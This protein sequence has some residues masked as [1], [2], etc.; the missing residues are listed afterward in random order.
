VDALEAKTVA[1]APRIRPFVRRTFVGLLAPLTLLPLACDLADS[2]SIAR[3]YLPRSAHQAYGYSLIQARLTQSALGRDWLAATER[4][5]GQPAVVALPHAVDVSFDAST[6]AAWGYRL[7]GRAGQRIRAEIGVDAVERV[8]TFVDV[9]RVD[10]D[11]IAHIASAPPQPA[12]AEGPPKH[13]VEWQV[14]EP[15]DYILRVQPE[16]LRSGS[17]HVE[18]DAAPLLAFPVTGLDWRAIQS[19]FGADRDGGARAHRGV[20]IFAQRGTN[21]VAA[22]DA[23]VTRVDSTAR[24]GNVVWLQPLFGEMRLYYAHLDT[25]L[26]APGQFVQSGEVVGTVGNTGNAR[27]TPP[28]LHFGVYLRRRGMGGGAT[29][30]TYFLH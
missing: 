30:P 13:T 3:P 10:G 28:H 2:E 14:L 15:G 19:G 12:F 16:L 8:E 1:S 11:A 24:G 6:A 7:S 29:D 22:V 23:W 20:D 26:V 27:T 5:L 9:F 4:A 17:V 21:A 18:I 25:Q